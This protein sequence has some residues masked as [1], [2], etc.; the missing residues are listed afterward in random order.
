MFGDDW[1]FQKDGARPHAHATLQEW[2][3]N[4]FPSFIDKNHW[5]PNSS[6]LNPLD[7]CIWNEIVQV[8]K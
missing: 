2:G 6:H 8:I 3:V 7:Y 4:S 1:T 5:P